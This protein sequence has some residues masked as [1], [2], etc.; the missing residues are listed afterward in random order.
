MVG[1]RSV[2][3]NAAE[4]LYAT[5]GSVSYIVQPMRDA[6]SSVVKVRVRQSGEN[7]WTSPRVSY[8]LFSIRCRKQAQPA[9]GE[10][11]DSSSLARPATGA[12][13]IGRLP[14]T[15]SAAVDATG[16]PEW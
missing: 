6:L 2:V 4:D 1:Q 13:G 10:L 12:P 15:R 11:L 7:R 8:C 9:T 14:G 16:A 3:L 5:F